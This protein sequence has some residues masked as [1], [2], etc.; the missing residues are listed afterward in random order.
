LLLLGQNR[1][2]LG[3]ASPNRFLPSL[4]E[5]FQIGVTFFLTLIAW[6]FFRADSIST[7]LSMIYEIFFDFKFSVLEL[8]SMANSFDLTIKHI[9]FVGFFLLVEW[10][11]R[12]KQHALQLDNVKIPSVLKWVLYYALI[13]SIFYIG[14]GQQDFI[15]FQF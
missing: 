15:Y 12:D 3:N 5:V 8:R 14:G 13:L 9:S 10:L 2:N 4:R 7:A 1:K 11:Q 6:I